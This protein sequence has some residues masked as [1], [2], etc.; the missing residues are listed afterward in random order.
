[1]RFLC[2][3]FSW[4]STNDCTLLD[5]CSFLATIKAKHLWKCCRCRMLLLVVQ[6]ARRRH[7]WGQQLLLKHRTMH[8]LKLFFFFFLSASH[9]FCT[10]SANICV[11]LH[12]CGSRVDSPCTCAIAFMCERAMACVSVCSS[13]S[14]DRLRALRPL[15]GFLICM[16]A[17]SL[18]DHNKMSPECILRARRVY[19]RCP[20]SSGFT[21][22]IFPEHVDNLSSPPSF[23]SHSFSCLHPNF[24]PLLC[25]PYLLYTSGLLDSQHTMRMFDSCSLNEIGTCWSISHLMVRHVFSGVSL[26]ISDPKDC[27]LYHC[28]L[29]Y[30]SQLTC[31]SD[32]SR[33]PEACTHFN[34]AVTLRPCR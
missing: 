13:I 3:H 22:N 15:L 14:A 16:F 32:S 29:T 2:D 9:L 23:S 12:F 10:F 28:V 31:A 1:M 11:R 24:V 18:R 27:Q 25:F 4:I 34:Y 7:R 26:H 21:W 20:V 17:V 19:H 30:I 33:Q 6:Q 8:M 5:T